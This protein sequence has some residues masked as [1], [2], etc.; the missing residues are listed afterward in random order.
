MS[1]VKVSTR[2]PRA[3]WTA[4]FPGQSRAD[5]REFA[6]RIDDINPLHHDPIAAQEVGFQDIL[7]TGVRIFGFVSAA[8]ARELGRVIP[9]RI[10][11]I[12][13]V[14]P[15]YEG[16]PVTV[17]CEVVRYRHPIAKLNVF[18]TSGEQNITECQ[19]ITVRLLGK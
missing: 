12:D 8:I 4:Y 3:A 10:E 2:L 9:T 19:T 7:T 15:L 13:F 11:V 18:V 16:M 14:N 17:Y 1:D 6:D 5:I